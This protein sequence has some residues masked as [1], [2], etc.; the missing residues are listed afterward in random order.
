MLRKVL[1]DYTLSD[2]TFLSAGTTVSCNIVTAHFHNARYSDPYTF[3]GNR[4]LEETESA[5]HQMSGVSA[6]FLS[7][8]YG[9]HAW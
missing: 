9:R 5:K 6:D 1:V 4:F 7:F 3:D 8:G 2:G